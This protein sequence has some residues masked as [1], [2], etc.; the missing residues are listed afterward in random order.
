MRAERADRGAY[1][2]VIEPESPDNE[3]PVVVEEDLRT[4]FGGAIGAA[5]AR[6]VR[7][8]RQFPSMTAVAVTVRPWPR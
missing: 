2:F 5:L 4:G 3:A 8:R 6:V 7:L 1:M